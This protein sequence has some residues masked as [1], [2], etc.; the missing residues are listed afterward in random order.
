MSIKQIFLKKEMNSL[1]AI[2]VFAAV[3]AVLVYR[4]FH[5]IDTTDETFYFATA[6][7]FCDGDMLFKDDWNR[8]QVYGLLMVPFYRAYV[9]FNGSNEGIILFARLLFI[10]LSLA[11][12]YFLYV[13]LIEYN[14]SRAASLVISLCELVYARGN[15]I[16]MSYYSLGFLTF[17]LTILCWMMAERRQRDWYRI[18]AGV[19]FSVSV[20]CMPYMVI[21]FGIMWVYAGYKYLKGYKAYVEKAWR[22]TLGCVASAVT[23]LIYY[24]QMIPWS[25]LL[26]YVFVVFS[27]PGMEKEGPLFQYWDL[28]V[29]MVSVFFKYTWPIYFMTFIMSVLIGK[30]I[31]KSTGLK[32]WM[33]GILLLEFIIQAVYVRGYFEGGIIAV[34]FLFIFQLQLLYPEYRLKELEQYFLVPGVFFAAVWVVGSNVGQRVVNMGFLLIDIWGISLL[35]YIVSKE[36]I[37]KYMLAPAYIMLGTLVLI[38]CFDIYRDGA[39]GKLTYQ[40]SEGIMKGI[41]TEPERGKAYESAVELLRNNTKEGDII[42]VL[43][44]NP[45]GYL[46]TSAS[47]GAYTTWQ[48]SDGETRL[49]Q[50]YETFPEKVPNVILVPGDAVNTYE[51]WKYSSH[52]VGMYEGEHLELYGILSQIVEEGKFEKLDAGG[53][54]LYKSVE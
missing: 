32:K 36:R 17:L 25:K 41:Y 39:L 40:V 16:T 46:E 7:R 18:I 53:T 21:I 35:W 12:A 26:E 1:L 44:C 42:A 29:Y 2:C 31:I 27:D 49:I 3:G 37:Y 30:K 20:L 24:F 28:L 48:F 22:M 54:V 34:F 15:I 5:G 45:W 11:I 52:G 8:G 43:G 10:F 51:Y 6:K 9:F 19:N 4:A 50:Y 13:L 23:F 38:R 33:I 47:C 14:V